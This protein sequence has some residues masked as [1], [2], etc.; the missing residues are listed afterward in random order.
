MRAAELIDWDELHEALR[1]YCSTRGRQGKPVRLVVGVQLLK[2][3]Y[4]ISDDR[5][6]EE[7]HE[8]AYWQSFCGFECF[9]RGLILDATT[10]V[11]FRNRIGLEGMQHIET[12][13]LSTWCS[14]GL[15]KTRRVAVDTTAQPKI[16]PIPRMLICYTA[17]VSASSSR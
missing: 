8:N 14:M 13:L 15:V 6:V 1:F 10:L 9:Q 11:K 12:V 17:S 4:K 16:S 7:L 3:H 2:H 5:A